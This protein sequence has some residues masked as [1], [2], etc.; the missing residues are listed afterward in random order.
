[1]SNLLSFVALILLG[2]LLVLDPHISYQ[3]LLADCGDDISL[4]SHLELAKEH[5]K[6]HYHEQYMPKLSTI[7]PQPS[8]PVILTSAPHI[9][10]RM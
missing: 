6:V 7:T 4:K 5:L 8:T 9:H 2:H 10:P 1:M 3:G